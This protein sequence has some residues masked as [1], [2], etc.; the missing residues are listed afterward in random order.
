MPTT[1]FKQDFEILRNPI[2]CVG[3]L[4]VILAI[5]ASAVLLT[6]VEVLYWWQAA[7]FGGSVLVLLLAFGWSIEHIKHMD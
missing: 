7:I 4:T 1:S 6:L 3:I 2:W 5:T